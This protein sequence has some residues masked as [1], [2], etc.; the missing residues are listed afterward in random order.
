MFTESDFNLGGTGTGGAEGSDWATSTIFFDEDNTIFDT[1]PGTLAAGTYRI[2]ISAKSPLATDQVTFQIGSSSAEIKMAVLDSVNDWPSGGE[3][4]Q[5]SQQWVEFS[6]QNGTYPFVW[7]GGD[8][9]ELGLSA[10]HGGTYT[11]AGIAFVQQ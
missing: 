6:N 9:V 1:A 4:I 10:T 5:S 2:Y 7:G 11:L 8:L 3:N